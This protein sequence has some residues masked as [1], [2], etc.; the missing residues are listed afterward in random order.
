MSSMQ[1]EIVMYDLSKFKA[2]GCSV[3]EI[4]KQSIVANH[5]KLYKPDEFWGKRK[6][7]MNSPEQI[8]AHIKTTYK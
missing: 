1:T 4:I 3:I 6:N 8:R 5:K 7:N 2:E